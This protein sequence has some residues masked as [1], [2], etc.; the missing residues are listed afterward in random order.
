[1]AAAETIA[2]AAAM[3]PIAP[4]HAAA[5]KDEAEE[6]EA[7]AA[8]NQRL[9]AAVDLIPGE[10]VAAQPMALW[11]APM[12]DMQLLAAAEANRTRPLRVAVVADNMPA[13]AAVDNVP[14]AAA[15]TPAADIINS[16]LLN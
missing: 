7:A 9:A 13:V 8:T 12:P 16:Y 6:H 3:L 4:S 10:R 14:A 5:V 2:A 15:D 11:R 1:M